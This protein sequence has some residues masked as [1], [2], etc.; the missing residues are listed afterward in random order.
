MEALILAVAALTALVLI[1]AGYWTAVS[2]MRWTPVIVV[3]VAAAWF[4]ARTG[5]TPIEALIVGA[6]AGMVVRHLRR[7]AED[8]LDWSD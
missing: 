6:L 8:R 5:A 1:D 4:A 2:L 3:A 7:I